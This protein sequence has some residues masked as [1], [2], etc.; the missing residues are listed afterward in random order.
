[1][2]TC[3]VHTKSNELVAQTVDKRNFANSLFILKEIYYN[4][5]VRLL[6]VPKIKLTNLTFFYGKMI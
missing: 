4:I 6:I 1:M 3:C 2:N 5:N